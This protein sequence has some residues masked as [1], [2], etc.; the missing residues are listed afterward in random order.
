MKRDYAEFGLIPLIPLFNERFGASVRTCSWSEETGFHQGR[1]SV[2][3]ERYAK[4]L[5]SIRGRDIPWFMSDMGRRPSVLDLGLM[6]ETH[7]R[8]VD[9]W[10]DPGITGL[11]DVLDSFSM[12]V[13]SLIISTLDAPSMETYDEI[14]DVSDSCIPMLAFDG[15]SCRLGSA[16]TDIMGTVREMCDIGY[17]EIMVM[18]LPMLGRNMGINEELWRS[19]SSLDARVI[20]CGGM[21]ENSLP[22][23]TDCG[24]WKAV[25]DPLLPPDE[26]TRDTWSADETASPGAHPTVIGVPDAL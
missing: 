15:S 6:K 23:L 13:D 26:E 21:T 14:I 17:E 18:D 24:Y 3:F 2:P 16:R 12:D 11:D 22:F 7:I 20:P 8:G 9:R 5:K 1:R 25:R 4:W 10:F 19:L